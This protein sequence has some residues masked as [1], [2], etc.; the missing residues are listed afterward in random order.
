M[1]AGTQYARSLAKGVEMLTSP[2]QPFEV[3]KKT[4][5]GISHTVFAGMPDNLRDLFAVGE[6]HGDLDFLVYGDERW[7]FSETFIEARKL[8]AALHEDYNIQA[9]DR[10]AI[11]CRNY[12]EWCIAYLAITGMGAIAVLLNSWWTAEE[13]E[14]GIENCDPKLLIVDERRLDAIEKYM[15]ER[16]LP[17]IAI[18]AKRALPAGC[19]DYKDVIKGRDGSAWPDIAVHAENP[20]TIFYTSGSTNHPKGV[21]S[22]G[23]A[24]MTTL[25]TWAMVGTS[26]KIIDGTLDDTSAPQLGVLLCLPLFHITGCNSTFML[27]TLLGRKIVFI[28]KWNVSES[29]RL[30]EKERLTNFVGVPTMTYE[31]LHA[32][33]RDK[34]DLSSLTDIGA[35]GAS[36]PAHQVAELKNTFNSHI[37]IGFGM[38]E[39][40]ALGALNG[41]ESYLEKPASTGTPFTPTVE[42]KILDDQ[43]KACPA[44][45]IGELVIKTAANMLC[46]WQNPEAT[47]ETLKDGWL[48]TGDLA[49]LDE[50]NFLFIVDRKK[51][52]II[53][54]GENISTQEIESALTH[55]KNVRDACVFALPDERMGEIV[56]AVIQ[57]DDSSLTE[58]AVKSYLLEHI[59]H[60]K[61]PRR[62]WVQSEP[63]PIIGSSKVDKKGLQKHYSD[64]INKEGS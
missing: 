34:Y 53:S 58:E 11:A 27:S 48:M 57:A 5:D 15:A 44:G 24:L 43:G 62:L 46:Y 16:K 25:L 26:Q 56:G 33:D 19:C 41:R 18:R 12:P 59:A 29:L 13:L 2:G 30:I 63:L 28:D 39:T 50:E 22:N 7:T 31:L 60:F 9:G 14:Y 52:I 54:G 32:P 8:A 42:M 49:Y 35:G 21:L 64:L 36:R 61:I 10:V 3:V 51:S 45:T 40:N 1:T 23:R 20:S 38:T 55:H 6:A 37:S 17:S 47:A 4:L